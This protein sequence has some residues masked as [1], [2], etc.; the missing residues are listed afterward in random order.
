MKTDII[1][2][3][4]MALTCALIA[5]EPKEW[6]L[7]TTTKGKEYHNAKLTAVEPSGIKITHADGL[8]RIPFEQLP[9]D[10]RSTFKVDPAQAA[11]HKAKLAADQQNALQ[12]QEAAKAKAREADL[13][14]VRSA[15]AKAGKG[16]E[17]IPGVGALEIKAQHMSGG[18]STDTTWQTVWGSYN[19][20][21]T[22]KHGVGILLD[23]RSREVLKV[24]VE[25]GWITKDAA[26]NK[27]YVTM[28]GHEKAELVQGHPSAHYATMAVTSQDDKYNALG[29]REQSGEE[30]RG[31]VVRVKNKQDTVIAVAASLPEFAKYAAVEWEKP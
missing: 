30:Y 23:T 16:E 21:I 17:F 22:G 4:L 5:E 7:L 20:T 10:I 25:W 13:A 14:S 27:R 1:V 18:R 9:D 11:A 2:L 29:I 19:K 31:W 15:D 26:S 28:G 12:M 24:T 8:A 3:A 6:P